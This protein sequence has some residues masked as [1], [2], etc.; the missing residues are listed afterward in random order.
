MRINDSGK[1]RDFTACHD[2]QWHQ[3]QWL[4]KTDLFFFTPLQVFS[5]SV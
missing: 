5:I 1:S 4:R 3:N 2:N